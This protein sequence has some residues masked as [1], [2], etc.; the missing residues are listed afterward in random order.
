MWAVITT[1]STDKGTRTVVG[2]VAGWDYRAP[3]VALINADTGEYIGLFVVG[4][5]DYD[6]KS[7]VAETRE[8]ALDK[9]GIGFPGEQS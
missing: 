6:V 8:E 1:T 5:R 4:D 7:F 2:P 9:A 3:R